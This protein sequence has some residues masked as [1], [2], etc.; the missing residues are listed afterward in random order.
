MTGR[1]LA[2]GDRIEQLIDSLHAG[3]W[4]GVA[5]QVDE[6]LRLITDL[7]GA[8]LARILELAGQA[9][10]D[11]DADQDAG[12]GADLVARL[13]DDE[14]VGGLL[15]VHDLHPVSLEARLESA[16]AGVRPLLHAHGGDVELVD[17]DPAAGA[18][19][20]RLLG[21]CDGCPASSVT[22]QQAVEAAILAAAPEVRIID[23]EPSAEPDTK[24]AGVDTPVRLRA[25]PTYDA[26]PAGV[27]G[28]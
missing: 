24:P 5:E 14:L 4:P 27:A 2:N 19:R 21:T 15:L 16:L 23:V 18:V 3:G 20:L 17:T 11:P 25:K 6:L 12:P 22:L 7:Y 28:A 13:A 8:G 10:A 9:D 26:C 1:N